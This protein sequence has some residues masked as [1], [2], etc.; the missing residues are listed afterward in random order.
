MLSCV[1]I[2]ETCGINIPKSKPI[3]LLE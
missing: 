3:F 2:K 1:E